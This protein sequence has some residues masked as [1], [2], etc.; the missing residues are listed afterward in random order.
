MQKIRDGY[1]FNDENIKIGFTNRNVDAKNSEDM[2]RFSGEY[3][4]NYSNIVFNT[5][6]HGTDVRIVESE[7]DITDNRKESDGLITSL[8]TTPL[9]IFTADCVPVVFYD[10]KQGV[11]ALAHAGWRGTYGNIAG[12]IVNIMRNKY[13]CKV[14]MLRLL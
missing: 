8:Q 3:G 1:L 7:A 2:K 6:V 9:L 14:E 12:E 11:V 13:G 4:F 10:K 5:Q